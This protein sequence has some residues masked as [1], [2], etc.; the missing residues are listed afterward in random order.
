MNGYHWKRVLLGELGEECVWIRWG[1]QKFTTRNSNW[2]SRFAQWFRSVP[3][4]YFVPL[5]I[6]FIQIKN[7]KKNTIKPFHYLKIIFG[8]EQLS[9]GMYSSNKKTQAWNFLNSHERNVRII[10]SVNFSA[11]VLGLFAMKSCILIHTKLA[12]LSN[13]LHTSTHNT[14][15][16]V[17]TFSQFLQRRE[18]YTQLLSFLHKERRCGRMA[19]GTKTQSQCEY[20]NTGP[21]ENLWRLGGKCRENIS[22]LRT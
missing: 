20:G 12:H 13:S 21:L 8:L 10:L 15:T 11:L 5:V 3:E 2:K 9:V 1:W 4:Y 22:N 16:I 6:F 19:F 17:Q 7:R 18:K 14:N